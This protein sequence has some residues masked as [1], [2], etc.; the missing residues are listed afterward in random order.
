MSRPNN[1]PDK[2]T[3]RKLYLDDVQSVEKIAVLYRCGAT[4]IR[5]LIRKH[6]IPLRKP[7]PYRGELSPGWRGGMTLWGGYILKSVPNHPAGKTNYGHYVPLHRLIMEKHLG[8]YLTAKEVVHHKNGDRTDNRLDNLQLFA[9]NG[10]H[11]AHHRTGKR[12]PLTPEGR[13]RMSQTASR[14]KVLRPASETLRSLYVD[15]LW[16]CAQI[17]KKFGCRSSLVA[18]ELH[19]IGVKMRGTG[20][21]SKARRCCV[22]TPPPPRANAPQMK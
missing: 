17:A 1:R 12:S 3:L 19:R 20:G 11:T 9:T 15:N 4:T 14:L 16:S 2:D 18:F 6:G 21:V 8:R 13:A 22:S 7:G 5:R 10:L